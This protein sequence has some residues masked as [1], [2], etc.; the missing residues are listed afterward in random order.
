MV[1]NRCYV[2]K[3]QIIGES[4]VIRG[5]YKSA[6]DAEYYCKKY[7]EHNSEKHGENFAWI[8]EYTND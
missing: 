5:T 3:T 7:N 8:E 1:G 4:E 2:V 6:L